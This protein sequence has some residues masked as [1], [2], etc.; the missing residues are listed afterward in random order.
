LAHLNQNLEGFLE[1]GIDGQIIGE[2][3]RASTSMAIEDTANDGV[4]RQAIMYVCLLLRVRF[5]KA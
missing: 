2:T 1:S 4:L 5:D 3:N